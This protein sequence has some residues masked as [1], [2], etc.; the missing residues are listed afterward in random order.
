LRERREGR[1]PASLLE[2]LQAH[3]ITLEIQ[4]RELRESQLALQR[5]RARYF[6]LFDS[7]PVP[8][9]V[10]DGRHNIQELN[11]PAG[12]LLGGDRTRFKH[13]PFFPHLIDADRV[14]FHHHVAFVLAR[15]ER[16][17][18]ELGLVMSDGS[19][20][21]LRL[22]S[23]AVPAESGENAV[24]LSAVIEPTAASADPDGL[25]VSEASGWRTHI[26]ATG[27]AAAVTSLSRGW[28]FCSPA[29]CELVG[30]TEAELRS[31][32]WIG[33][34]HPADRAREWVEWNR[35]LSG[36]SRGYVI[37]KRLLTRNG[38]DI[39]VRATVTFPSQRESSADLI[40]HTVEPIASL[41]SEAASIPTAARA[42]LEGWL[43]QDPRPASESA[44]S[45]SPWGRR[46]LFV[47]D[48]P[49][50]RDV[51]A[52]MIQSLGWAVDEASGGAEAL[53]RFGR[54]PG[55]Y[56]TVITDLAMPGMDGMSLL[57]ELRRIRRDVP[58]VFM[59]GLTESHSLDLD[60]GE[61][62]VAYLQKP[63]TMQRLQEVL[64]STAHSGRE[65]SHASPRPSPWA[66]PVV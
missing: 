43:V 5:A 45:A 57:R 64:G 42:D 14:R 38:R 39:R 3:Q 33:I 35:L 32:D 21:R 55:A 6:E 36:G 17:E 53:Q 37:E 18:V 26:A 7:A 2:D 51:A 54:D 20:R 34:T 13:R 63:F 47:D 25:S 15:R 24:C 19:V 4:N 46:V 56:A 29:L 11:L 30:C 40:F 58:C 1:L 61:A 44:S 10:F 23:Q 66:R 27:V 65:T 9:F 22:A 49:V 59:S 8:Y 41:N 28:V 52:R 60:G 12:E 62:G 50:V 16:A 31:L 48:E